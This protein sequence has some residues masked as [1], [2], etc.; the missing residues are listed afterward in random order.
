[1]KKLL[2]VTYLFAFICL[3]VSAQTETD[4]SQVNEKLVSKKGI[5][6]LP[7]QGEYALGF[8]A[9]PMLS[10]VG[11]LLSNN[12]ASSP[13]TDYAAGAYGYQAIY[14]KYMLSNNKAIRIRLGLIDT[15]NSDLY[16]VV[17]SSLTPDANAPEFVN[18]EI[19]SL[20]KS[21]ILAAGLEK[22]R[23]KSRIQGVYGGEVFFAFS[24][25]E[26]NTLYGNSIN[27]DFNTPVT[28]NNSYTSG[29]RLIEDNQSNVFTAGLRGFVG[30][31]YFILPKLSLGGEFG[32]SLRFTS[33]GTREQI[34]EYWDGATSSVKKYSYKSNNDSYKFLGLDTDNLSSSI[35]LIF[36]F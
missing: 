4:N 24:R 34:Y 3:A 32:Y 27:A 20:N 36:Y 16:P 22:R 30:I 23:G 19:V 7:E 18:D 8:D 21:F 11:N 29:R 15:K 28:Y 31:E 9:Y 33:S 26:T 35:N 25:Y 5:F 14:G 12:G 1:M 6:I 13:Y 2:A 17:K 10:Y